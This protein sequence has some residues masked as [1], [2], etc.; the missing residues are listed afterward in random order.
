R[1]PGPRALPEDLKAAARKITCESLR[2]SR[3]LAVG[4]AVRLRAA[5]PGLG[6]GRGSRRGLRVVVAHRRRVEPSLLKLP[7]L[8]IVV[9]AAAGV[10]LPVPVA[11]V[12]VAGVASV[13][14][15]LGRGDELGGGADDDLRR[16]HRGGEG[17]KEA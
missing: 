9:L 17:Y 16:G 10:V 8:L 15:G 2:G 6:P 14:D 13:G 5:M 7:R 12:P 3:D 1:G 4:A 11:V